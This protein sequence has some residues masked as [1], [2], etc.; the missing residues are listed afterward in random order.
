M[1]INH[2]PKSLNEALLLRKNP[3]LIPYA[4]GTDLMVSHD[5]DESRYLF[6]NKID[7]IRQITT[8]EKYIRFGAACTF[9]ETISHPLTAAILKEA[10]KQIAAPAIRNAGTLGGNIANGSAKADSAL[11]FMVTNSMLRLKSNDSERLLPIKDFYLGSAKTALASDELII[12]ILMPKHGIDNYYYKKVGARNALA[13]SR[14][15][16]AAIMELTGGKIINCA[17]S[18]GAVIDVIIRY[19]EIDE[20]LIGKTIEEAK[21]LKET[22]LDKYDKAIQ[23]RRGRVGIKYRK[24][25]C[26][27]LLKDFLECNGI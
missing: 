27:N 17:T 14:T 9:S 24:D 12:E 5:C 21:K 16:F 13:I 19:N 23:P 8:D 20:M 1:E 2:T 18:F 3:D 4:G 10:C 6:I 26:M 15:S 7:E 22:Y 11:I 25:I